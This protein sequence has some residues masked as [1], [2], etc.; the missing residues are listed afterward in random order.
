MIL[1]CVF[2][3]APVSVYAQEEPAQTAD[4]TNGVERI[5]EEQEVMPISEDGEAVPIS[6]DGEAMPINEEPVLEEVGE[7][8]TP[9]AQLVRSNSYLGATIG[10]IVILVGIGWFLTVNKEKLKR[11]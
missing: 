3:M 2:A 6:E 9:Q 1:L 7:K 4:E 8:E 11:K 5:N 10:G